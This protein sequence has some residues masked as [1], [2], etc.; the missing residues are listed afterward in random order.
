MSLKFQLYC[1]VV[2]Y[3]GH[4]HFFL[5]ND[6]SKKK[7]LK[8]TKY[9]GHHHNHLIHMDMVYMMMY[10]HRMDRLEHLDHYHNNLVHNNQ[11]I[12]IAK[13]VCVFS[14]FFFFTIQFYHQTKKKWNEKKCFKA[15]LH[16]TIDD[17]H[18]QF[19]PMGTFYY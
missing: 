2:I 8:I 3:F 17:H 10:D 13:R 16:R 1:D 9:S 5:P 18:D 7:Q 6:I 12:I 4:R 11:P 19:W 14:L 15:S